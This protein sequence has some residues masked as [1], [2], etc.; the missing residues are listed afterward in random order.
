MVRKYIFAKTLSVKFKHISFNAKTQDE[1]RNSKYGKNSCEKSI[2]KILTTV[3]QP[4]TFLSAEFCK[5]AQSSLQTNLYTTLYETFY[6]N[7]FIITRNVMISVI[8]QLGLKS[9]LALITNSM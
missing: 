6:L 4:G 7:R 2:W 5:N 1:M 8:P 9:T 3:H